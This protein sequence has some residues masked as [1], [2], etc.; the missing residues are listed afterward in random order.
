MA[1]ASTVQAF[2]SGRDRLG[3]NYSMSQACDSDFCIIR[4]N[5]MLNLARKSHRDAGFWG[6]RVK[7]LG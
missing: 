5:A 1:S 6:D 3:S 7:Q 2:P 4:L